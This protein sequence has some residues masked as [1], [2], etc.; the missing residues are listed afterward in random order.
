MA[1]IVS[2]A[3]LIGAATPAS[4]ATAQETTATTVRTTIG[5]TTVRADGT[6]IDVAL[7]D[8]G[9]VPVAGVPATQV[10]YGPD[11][12]LDAFNPAFKNLDTYG[13]GT[14]MASLILD[15]APKARIVSVK[16]GSATAPTTS[17][18]II[19]GIDWVTKNARTEGR[20]IRVLN[21]SFGLNND[22]SNGLIAAALYRAWLSGIV[23]V[24]AA[25]NAGNRATT[26]DSP[27]KDSRFL[28]V[29]AATADGKA[30]ATY[31]SGAT[32]LFARQPDVIAPGSD[33]VGA[34]V[35]GSYLD[36]M[37]PTA[38][39]DAEGFR[40]SGTSQA[41]AVTSGAAAL[42]LQQK[43]AYTPDQVKSAFTGSAK[44]V[45]G[46]QSTVQGRGLLNTSLASTAAATRAAPS[47]GLGLFSSAY[48]L[49]ATLAQLFAPLTTDIWTANGNGAGWSGNRWS[50][51]RW[52]AN[53]W[54]GNSW[55]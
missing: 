21:I 3:A 6:G 16:V 54:S 48:N 45:A 30:I 2:A 39:V 41:S 52:S 51:N 53:R 28:A 15:V 22:P 27:A 20:N 13:H 34:R 10:L 50:G 40:G 12:T 46:V 38:R 55:A 4:A 49:F 36:V 44:P 18:S 33:L 17:A 31:S 42:I 7:I 5:S 14:N 1:V 29:G 43:P 26:L 23:V 9:V 24:A 35:P 37:Y 47:L 32:G 19:A 25:G 8:T 11:L